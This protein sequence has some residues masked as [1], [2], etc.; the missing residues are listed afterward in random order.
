MKDQIVTSQR[1]PFV[2]VV[3][4]VRWVPRLKDRRKVAGRNSFSG[5]LSWG[6]FIGE[7][8]RNEQEKIRK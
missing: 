7:Q 2:L 5:G 6:R 1:R 4:V 3:D 8:S